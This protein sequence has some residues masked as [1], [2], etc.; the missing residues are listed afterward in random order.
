MLG[1][2]NV[3]LG[4]DGVG[5]VAVALLLD[6]YE[7]AARRARA[8]RRHARAVAAAVSRRRRR[9]SFSSTRSATTRRPGPSCGWTATTSRRPSRRGFRRTRSASPTCSTARAGSTATPRVV[10]LGI[11]PESIELGVGL[12]PRSRA[13]AGAGRAASSR[14]RPGSASALSAS[15]TR[16]PMRRLHPGR[17]RCGSSRPRALTSIAIFLARTAGW[18]FRRHPSPPPKRGAGAVRRLPSTARS[19]TASAATATVAARRLHAPTAR[20]HRSRPGA[21]RRHRRRVFFA[22]REGIRRT[23]MPSWR[24]LS[25]QERGTS[26]PTCCRSEKDRDEARPSHR[27]PRGRAGRR[28]PSLG[29][30]PGAEEG[31]AGRVRNDAAGVTIDAFGD[32]GARRFPRRLARDAAG[33]R[34]DSRAA[35]AADP[36]RARRGLLDRRQRA[37]APTAV[38]IPPDLA[39]CAGVPGRDLRSRRPPLPLPVHQLHQ[40]RAALHDRP[41]P[42]YDR[43]RTTMAA[44]TMCAACQARVRRPSRTAAFMRSPTPV[45]SADRALTLMTAR[46]HR[47]RQPDPIADA[48]AA[49][50]GGTDRRAQGPRRLSSRV[51]RDRRATPSR[52]CG[53]RKR[54]DE[55]PFAVMVRDLARR[56]SAS[57]S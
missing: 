19:A 35:R 47:H 54:R 15:H 46:G 38:S 50:C 34:R 49:R 45:R 57:R 52:A 25:E 56:A 9:A 36:G 21:S 27:D 12:S 40:L 23:P 24:N 30:P 41:R 4:D 31:V 53:S 33:R 22:I 17:C 48:A 51:R 5:A 11:V 8:R 37:P 32:G 7:P 6:R 20:L 1:L 28:L 2:G 44:F 16:G 3:L 55:K 13:I 42:P 26:R 39:T 14:K 29:L 10:L 18:R 43:R